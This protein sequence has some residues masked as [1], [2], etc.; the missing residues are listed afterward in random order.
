MYTAKDGQLLM[1]W[2]NCSDYGY[3]VGVARSKNG[4]ID[5]EWEHDEEIL[6]SSLQTGEHDGGCGI[7][8]T[9]LDGKVYLSAHSPNL[10]T[11]ER[12]ERLIFIPIYEEN[13]KLICGE[14]R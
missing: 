5:G 10:V 11:E 4:K 7:I 6:F 3:C 2:S 1:L 8:F 13:G 14:K 12:G 9:A